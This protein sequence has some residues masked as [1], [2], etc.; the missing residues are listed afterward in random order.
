[1]RAMRRDQKTDWLNGRSPVYSENI[2]HP[3]STKNSWTPN[4]P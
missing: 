1:M 3:E 2:S 4:S